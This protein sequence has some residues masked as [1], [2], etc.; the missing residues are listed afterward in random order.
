MWSLGLNHLYFVGILFFYLNCLILLPDAGGC[1]ELLY[2]V[3]SCD[4]FDTH[5]AKLHI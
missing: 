5:W 3:A 4:K 1:T 2:I